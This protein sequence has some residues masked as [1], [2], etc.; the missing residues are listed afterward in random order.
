MK[1]IMIEVIPHSQQRLPGSLGGD[2]QFDAE[3]NLLVRISDLGD[4]YFNFLFARHEMDEAILC[5]HAGITTEMVDA[6]ELNAKDTDDPDSFTGYP[7]SCYQQQHNDA[8]S[9]E[10]MMSRLLEIDWEEYGDAVEALNPEE[11]P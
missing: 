2:W 11:K 7:G 3:G 8:L 10:W 9:M 6:D 1:K 4:N 5:K